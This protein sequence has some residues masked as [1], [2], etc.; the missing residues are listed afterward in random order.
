MSD[1]V[2][3]ATEGDCRIA[4]ANGLRQLDCSF[5]ELKEWARQDRT[6]EGN[7]PSIKHRLVWVAIGD[8]ED[9]A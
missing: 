6:R 8:L 2:I 7:F 5:A 9:L 4:V 1:E 3:I